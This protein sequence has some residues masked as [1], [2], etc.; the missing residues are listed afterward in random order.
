M[1]T[2]LLNPFAF[3]ESAENINSPVTNFKFSQGDNEVPV[4]N[5]FSGN[6]FEIFVHQTSQ[7]SKVYFLDMF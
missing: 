3:D 2:L 5:L 6:E 4:K 7:V 1:S